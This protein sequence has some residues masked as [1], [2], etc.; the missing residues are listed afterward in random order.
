M[1]AAILMTVCATAAEWALFP[2]ARVWAGV[3]DPAGYAERYGSGRPSYLGWALYDIIG[4]AADFARAMILMADVN[5]KG[6]RDE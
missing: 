6:P 3:A 5:P 4:I 1:V 2:A